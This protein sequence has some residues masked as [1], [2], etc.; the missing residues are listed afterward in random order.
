[1]KKRI[2]SIG[3]V[4]LLVR[5]TSVWAADIDGSWIA[6]TPRGVE[7][8]ETIETVETVETVFSFK[9]NGTRLTG[10]VTNPQGET[11]ISDGKINGDEISFVIIRSFVGKEILLMCKGTVALNEIKFTCKE[12]SGMGQPQEFIAKREFQR[13]GD[14]PL[15]PTTAPT[16]QTPPTTITIEP[17][18]K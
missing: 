17:P 2:F 8:P 4:I 13:H 7:N 5:L 12:R 9:A 14:V 1:M 3:T 10:K 18:D 6:Q 11:V 16:R 15:L